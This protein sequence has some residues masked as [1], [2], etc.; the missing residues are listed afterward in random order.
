MLRG[1]GVGRNGEARTELKQPFAGTF[2][3]DILLPG[4]VKGNAG[5]LG[6]TSNG[7]QMQK[8]Y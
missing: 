7:C 6:E 3:L 8:V 5:R 1:R 4:T 2:K